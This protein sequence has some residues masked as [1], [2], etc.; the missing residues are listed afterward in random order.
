MEINTQKSIQRKLDFTNFM[1]TIGVKAIEKYG[2]SYM[3]YA[4]V[5]NNWRTQV[6]YFFKA[7]EDL[8]LWTKTFINNLQSNSLRYLRKLVKEIAEFLS[9]YTIRKYKTS[10]IEPVKQSEISALQNRIWN[11]C[12]HILKLRTQD[13]MARLRGQ[14]PKQKQ[15]V[16]KKQE[17]KK[18]Q[19]Y[20]AKY[21]ATITSHV[22]DI[23]A[24]A[25]TYR[26][27]F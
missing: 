7:E 8:I 12:T 18:Q 27:R 2:T 1:L 11:E 9:V 19:E 15:K 14:M 6:P 22:R 26:E 10:E 20:I 13:E 4:Q 25:R 5:Q 17:K 3:T 16:A 21:N 23:F 24:E